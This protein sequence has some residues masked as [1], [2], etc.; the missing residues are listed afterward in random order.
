MDI[1]RFASFIKIVDL[2]SLSRAA[3]QLGVTQ[4]SLSQQIAALEADLGAQLLLR[5]RQGVSATVAGRILYRHAQM[6]LR[7]LDNAKS[8]VQATGVAVAGHVSVGIPRSISTMTTVP[9]LVE[10]RRR[11]PDVSVRVTDNA[12][13]QL[14][15]LLLNGRLDMAILPTALQ[16]GPIIYRA[17]LVEGYFLVE[18]DDRDGEPGETVTMAAVSRLPLIATSCASPERDLVEEGFAAAGLTPNIV[19]EC[20]SLQETLA[21]VANGGVATLLPWASVRRF[22]GLLRQRRIVEDELL[23]E[24][25]L[26]I[27]D[28][29]SLSP[30]ATQIYDLVADVIRDELSTGRWLGASPVRGPAAS[31]GSAKDS[32]EA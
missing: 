20:D 4:P 19:L 32:E 16:K 29:L 15:E 17:L 23:C 10:I 26:C 28:S 14:A 5:G 13:T 7:Q 3:E 9:L 24:S 31:G 18:S 21:I 25:G 11:Y 6:I 27:S 12:V 30:A 2:G 1:S 8:A 22:P